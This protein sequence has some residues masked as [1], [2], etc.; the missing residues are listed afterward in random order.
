MQ[1]PAPIS[2]HNQV[3]KQQTGPLT[4]LVGSKLGCSGAS[5]PIRREFICFL[6]RSLLM[7]NAIKG[8]CKDEKSIRT[9]PAL[10]APKG[11]TPKATSLWL[12]YCLPTPDHPACGFPLKGRYTKEWDASLGCH[13]K[14]LPR[15]AFMSTDTWCKREAACR[16]RWG[17]EAFSP[18]VLSTSPFL[19]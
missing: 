5:S 11:L 1:A 8:S 16:N 17:Y 12:P 13:T 2:L 9:L 10:Q 15:L 3:S 18:R 14:D 6:T 19:S 7:W 4:F